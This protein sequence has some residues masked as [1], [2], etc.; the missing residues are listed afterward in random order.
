[1]TR[2]R[3]RRASLEFRLQPAPVDNRRPNWFFVVPFQ[4]AVFSNK[5]NYGS[6][7]AQAE[8]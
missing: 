4:A 1:L 5:S 6:Q 8:A 3:F 2:R 7:P